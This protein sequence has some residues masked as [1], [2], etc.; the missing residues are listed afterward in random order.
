[1]VSSS[2]TDPLDD[3]LATLLGQPP[4]LSKESSAALP[5][6]LRERYSIYSIHLFGHKFLLALSK[7]WS[8][9]ASPS[10][11]ELKKHA[12]RLS[13]S[14]GAPTVLVFRSL[15]SYLRNRLVHSRVPFI[16]PGKQAF[17]PPLLDLRERFANPVPEPRETFSPAAQCTVLYHLLREPISEV[18]LKEIAQKVHYSP[19]M[20]SKVKDELTAASVCQE[21]PTGRS[22]VLRFTAKGK[23]LWENAKP[24]LTSP[25][26][27]RHNVQWSNPIDPALL[28]GISALSLRSMIS[29]DN[30]PTY[31]LKDDE[32]RRLLEHRALLVNEDSETASA[33]V[34]EWSYNPS[35]LSNGRMVD[36]LSLYL[37][38][39]NSP[40]ERV[41][42]QLETMIDEIQ[43]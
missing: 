13:V 32:Y 40:D 31:A 11:G 6:F 28:A 30:L 16:V 21:V 15:P 34:E 37:S 9:S 8:N 20:M 1:M 18:P 29:D 36:P 22:V 2:L 27:R 35:L 42:Q 4:E 17:I 26:R 7:I 14:L 25:V 41:Q 19:M 5:L 24:R 10:G 3:Y 38:L 33:I 23:T 39:Q 12:E 43:W